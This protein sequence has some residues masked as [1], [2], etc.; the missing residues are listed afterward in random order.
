MK[1]ER[2]PFT[3]F[4]FIGYFIPGFLFLYILYLTVDTDFYSIL[5]LEKAPPSKESYE[6][7]VFT[8]FIF[9]FSWFI[10]H[11]LSLVSH[12][13]QNRAKSL[14]ENDSES[15]CFWNTLFFNQAKKSIFKGFKKEDFDKLKSALLKKVDAFPNVA[16]KETENKNISEENIS[17][18]LFLKSAS[19]YLK[20]ANEGTSVTIIYN[21]LVIQG[22]FRA[23]TMCFVLHFFI[24][25]FL[26]CFLP[27]DWCW[28]EPCVFEHRWWVLGFHII[29][30]YL[31]FLI[32]LKYYRRMIEENVVY[33]MCALSDV[34]SDNSPSEIAP[35]S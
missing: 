24:L 15:S 4:D 29:T 30:A 12:L 31:C 6:Y 34:P 3:V 22:A 19:N 2:T 9:I 18:A 21:Y 27:S 35:E 23:F 33:L 1:V 25:A 10:G 13:F 32:Y 26:P 11:L 28:I 14:F 20:Q 7:I 17:T 16:K 5:K 8:I